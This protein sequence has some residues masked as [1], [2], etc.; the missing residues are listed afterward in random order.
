VLVVSEE[1]R[2]LKPFSHR[3]EFSGVVGDARTFACEASTLVVDDGVML[4]AQ[5][6][7][8]FGKSPWVGPAGAIKVQSQ[9]HSLIV[10]QSIWECKIC[11]FSTTCERCTGPVDR[12]YLEKMVYFFLMP[13][14]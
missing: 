13:M 11:L 14:L 5:G 3:E 8:V 10:A 4:A 7:P 1:T 12:V 9:S 2:V 6:V